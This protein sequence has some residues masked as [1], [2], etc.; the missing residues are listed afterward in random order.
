MATLFLKYRPKTFT[1][2]VGQ[3]PIV[4]TLQNALKT[5]NPSH[6]Y[7]F[8]GSRGTG[9]TSSARIFAKG[10]NCEKM[11]DG[12]P[13]GTC[14][15]CI[16]IA[17]GHLIDI[18]E[19]DAASHTGVENIRNI[20]EKMEFAPTYAKRKVYIIDEV[21]MLSKGAFNALLK[22]LE[23]PP[24]HVY[25]LLA[26]TELQKIPETI[27]SRCQ[28]FI[29]HR[30]SLEQL[31][32]R[33][34]DICTKEGFTTTPDALQIIAKKAEGGLRDAISLLEQIA[35]ETENNIT[36]QSVRASLGI[37][38]SETLEKF[39]LSITNKDLETGFQILK[40]INEEGGDFRSFGHDF[41][42]FLRE[43]LHNNLSN[44]S[45]LNLI[46]SSI[47]EIETALARLKTSPIVEL[48]LEIA[49]VNI[50]TQKTTPHVGD[51][52]KPSQSNTKTEPTKI[53]VQTPPQKPETIPISDQDSYKPPQ[54]NKEIVSNKSTN[55][56]SENTP[57]ERNESQTTTHE[58][59]SLNF[60]PDILQSKMKEIADRAQI[61]I[62][63]KRSFLTTVPKID[64]GA[65][66]FLT[67]SE[68]HRDKLIPPAVQGALQ[69]AIQE[70]FQTEASIKFT[71][72]SIQRTQK[73]VKK[74]EK[75]SVD[76]F[77]SF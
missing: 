58:L 8:C 9:K 66:D 36:E 39:W 52:F 77:L 74:E 11:K 73:A 48:P 49:L 22:T 55:T 61:P 10:L 43:K 32:N 17:E 25:F 27:V 4:R 38:S 75:V 41:L 14:K 18:I 26:T 15:T 62:F 31:V 67:D 68:F 3:E 72:G 44:P 19:I 50:C 6:A 7:L 53:S 70:L 65:I 51:G 40:T 57:S 33:L 30:F 23:E 21:H 24:E 64:G 12:N 56:S 5:E 71:K 69:K 42:G 54:T 20:I 28:T 13:C 59:Q 37:S 1:D 29:F 16:D 34:D 45:E 46:L 47:E 35:A 76:D 63:A 60:T 2:L